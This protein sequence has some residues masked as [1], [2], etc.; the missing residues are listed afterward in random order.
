MINLKYFVI[1]TV[2]Y[3]SFS[4]ADIVL[5]SDILS[6]GQANTYEW[7]GLPIVVIKRTEEQLKKLHLTNHKFDEYEYLAAVKLAAKMLGN[8]IA[9]QLYLP[10]SNKK[11]VYE[12]KNGPIF[13]ALNLSLASGCKLVVIE[14]EFLD[15]CSGQKFDLA[16]RGIGHD[17][18]M[19]IP[20]NSMDNK[21]V[22]IFEQIQSTQ[23]I[24]FY[25]KQQQDARRNDCGNL[26]QLIDWDK[27]TEIIKFI[28]VNPKCLTELDS[29]GNTVLHKLS[30]KGYLNLIGQENI[31]KLDL[32][33]LNNIGETPLSIAIKMGQDSSVEWLLSHGVARTKVCNEAICSM[34]YK[35]LIDKFYKK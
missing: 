19:L 10:K 35:E 20:A 24:D 1:L 16:G 22:R 4:W 3:S 13:I 26:D 32:N 31:E 12:I 8:E 15:P 6:D 14:E 18:Y 5:S 17:G 21:K 34:G 33:A 28:E 9:T 29:M 27:K 23:I 11:Q 7:N 2:F 25:E 30:G